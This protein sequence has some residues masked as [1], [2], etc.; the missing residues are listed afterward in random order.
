MARPTRT[1]QAC[2]SVSL[3]LGCGDDVGLAEEPGL[4]PTELDLV[5]KGRCA[6]AEFGSGLG[7]GEHPLALRLFGLFHQVGLDLAQPALHRLATTLVGPD[8]DLG[9]P[10]RLR[11]IA[12]GR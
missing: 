7:E 11:A 12:D 3:Q 9:L 2:S 6:D 1:P 8:P 5:A 4:H 10:P